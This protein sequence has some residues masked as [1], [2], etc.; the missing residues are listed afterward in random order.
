MRC[1]PASL[2]AMI[3]F[4]AIGADKKPSEFVP[5][6]NGKDL[7]G[8]HVMNDGK[9]TATEKVIFLNRG[10]G[11]LR[12]DRQYG[13]FELRI[14][15]RFLNKGANSGIFFRAKND[16]G[17]ATAYQVQTMD[18]DTIGDLYTRKLA[19]PK[20][21]RDAERVKKAMK[22]AGEWLTYLITA[23]GEHLEVR[24]NGELITTADGLAT[25]PGY[26]GLQGEGGLLEFRKIEI[27]ELSAMPGE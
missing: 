20:I 12:S 10:G 15:F 23:N 21:N 8:W 11:W 7:S 25:E 24:L 2:A 5:L 13:D 17:P 26:I 3:A 18:G 14:E 22:P 19:M 27:R 1:L 16:K 4:S 6:F 9:F